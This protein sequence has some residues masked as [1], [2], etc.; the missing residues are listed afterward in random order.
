MCPP[1]PAAL[2]PSSRA[3]YKMKVKNC[4]SPLWDLCGHSETPIRGR[5]VEL[6]EGLNSNA[7]CTTHRLSDLGAVM[8]QGSPHPTP[9]ISLLICQMIT[10]Y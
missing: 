8:G 6:S 2:P 4:F 5:K 1:F 7:H 10:L 3:D 9:S